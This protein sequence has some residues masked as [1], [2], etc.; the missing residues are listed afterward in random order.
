MC[1]HNFST[2]MYDSNAWQC[3]V[4]PGTS[5]LGRMLRWNPLPLRTAA[6]GGARP[7]SALHP[8]GVKTHSLHGKL[9]F[10]LTATKVS[11]TSGV[12]SSLA[13][14]VL[15]DVQQFESGDNK[16]HMH[17]DTAHED[18]LSLSRGISVLARC[19]AKCQCMQH[20]CDTHLLL[21]RAMRR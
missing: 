2:H 21:T 18:L 1:K 9:Q 12:L 20:G 10:Q 19:S 17:V 7:R 16:R 4:T 14:C 3:V 5:S 6:H 8:Q 13:R 15:C 11:A